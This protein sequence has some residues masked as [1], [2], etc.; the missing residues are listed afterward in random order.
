M[1]G[2]M[3]SELIFFPFT[4]EILALHALAGSESECALLGST[5]KFQLGSDPRPK[6]PMGRFQWSQI[7][8]AGKYQR[9]QR[10]VH[11]MTQ[12]NWVLTLPVNPQAACLW[13]LWLQAFR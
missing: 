1:I 2:S 11:V 12:Y 7:P 4:M 10:Y 8:T 6:L 13:P 9:I 5:R 3:I